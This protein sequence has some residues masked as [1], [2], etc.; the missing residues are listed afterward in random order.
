[1]LDP[2]SFRMLLVALVGWLDQRQQDEVAYLIEENHILR[3]QMRGRIC[4]TDEERHRLVVFGHRL[5]CRRLGSTQFSDTSPSVNSPW[6]SG[7]IVSIPL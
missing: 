2:F 1:V 5:S 4:L 7:S 6:M 3:R